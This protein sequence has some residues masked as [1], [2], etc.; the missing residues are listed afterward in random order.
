MALMV[1]ASLTAD[2]TALAGD[3][4]NSSVGG[5]DVSA[6]L[7]CYS[8]EFSASSPEGKESQFSPLRFRKRSSENTPEL[9]K[10]S[11]LK[12][13]ISGTFHMFDADPNSGQ[14]RERF[15]VVITGAQIVNLSTASP[16]A[17]NPSLAPMPQYDLVELA[18]KTMSINELT[19]GTKY[20]WSP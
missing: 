11:L 13:K 2:D 9:W 20:E 4:T 19:S 7:E 5:V 10:A 6:M 3:S 17:S 14:T 8:L 18:P 15:R 12:Q 1:Y 16:D